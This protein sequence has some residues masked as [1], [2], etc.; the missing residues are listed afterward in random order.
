MS[1]YIIAGGPYQLAYRKL[2][3]TGFQLHWQ[4][5]TD[6]RTRARNKTKFTCGACGQNAWAKL[7]AF[8]LCGHCEEPMQPPPT[9][10]TI[11]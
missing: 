5:H 9:S 8:L 1:D 7:D 10:A 6:P 2:A 4:S 11:S 3:Q